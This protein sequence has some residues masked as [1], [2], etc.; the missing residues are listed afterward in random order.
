MRYVDSM[1][2]AHMIVGR[3]LGAAGIAFSLITSGCT[4]YGSARQRQLTH[5]RED[6]LLIREDIRRLAG[7]IETLETETDQLYRELTAL[8][9]E[10]AR[11]TENQRQDTDRRLNDLERRIAE[12]D[13]TREKDKQEIVDRLSRTI[14]QII[15]STAQRDRT[16][17]PRAASGYGYEHTVQPGETLSQIAAAYGVTA[18]VIIEA[19]DIRNPDMLRVGQVLFIPE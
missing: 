10:Q 4:T 19:N 14:E 16:R 9:E 2:K 15:A 3:V 6:M 13:R 17:G 7:R 1:M 8:R 5:E 18:R 11:G 12:V